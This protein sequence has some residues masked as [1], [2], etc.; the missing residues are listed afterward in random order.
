M[1]SHSS[2]NFYPGSLLKSWLLVFGLF[3]LSFS[4]SGQ[5]GM[6]LYQ[7][8]FIPQASYLN[9]ANTPHARFYISLPGISGI[10]AGLRT[11]YFSMKEGNVGLGT[12][13][14]DYD[15]DA[16]ISTFADRANFTNT[17]GLRLGADLFGFGIRSGQ[18]YIGFN[19][20]EEF[21]AN[22]EFPDEAFWFLDEYNQKKAA[23]DLP[24]LMTGAR[25]SVSQYRPITLQ[26]AYDI[27]PTFTLGGQVSYISGV[28]TLNATSDTLFA[29][30]SESPKGF[31]IVGSLRSQS[32]GFI[33]ADSSNVK[34]VFLNPQNSGV[35]F[36]LGGRLTTL[37]DRLDITFSAVNFGR[38]FWTQKVG[39]TYINDATFEKA[40]SLE[41]VLDALL[42][43]QE[44]ANFSF[45]QNLTPEFY[46]GANYFLNRSL[47]VGAL[48]QA[49]PVF[50][51]LQSAFGLF[52]NARPT[53][54]FGVT[55]GY[56]YSN[57]THNIPLGI[58]FQPGP[59]QIYLISDNALAFAFPG[60]A[61][62]FHLNMGINLVFGKTMRPW[63]ETAPKAGA[64]ES[65]PGVYVPE[66][67]PEEET[68]PEFVADTIPAPGD[69]L[70]MEDEPDVTTYLVTSPMFLY[71]GP[72]AATTVLDTIAPNTVMTVLQ[73]RLPD[74]W[75]VEY[76]DQSGW[77]QPRSIRP[78]LELPVSEQE[79]EEL[80]EPT[81]SFTPQDYIMLD[82]T[83]MRETPAETA[84][85]I[86]WMKKWD[87][88]VV[89]EKTNSSWWKIRHEG[90]QGYV[91]SAMLNPR[92]ENYVRPEE[93]Q[94]EEPAPQTVTPVPSNYGIY[95]I[96]A[97]TSLRAAAT[98]TSNSLKRLRTGNEVLVLEKTN[99][100]WWKVEASGLTGYVK[101]ANLTDQ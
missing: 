12:R 99:A 48:V 35:A 79:T 65:Y 20:R 5:G 59:I 58:N 39:E 44:K 73:K 101:A 47:S 8:P 43:V 51:S 88:V 15:L 76:G 56:L 45:N 14:R 19:I 91:K 37:D 92:P 46:L 90:R 17:L 100:L 55:S 95:R 25:F 33:E 27:L 42:S 75:Y 84:P 36:G 87:E 69:P 81:V 13:W 41:D 94:T 4:L 10:Q 22:L 64:V 2:F 26:Y 96:T 30:A 52:F 78:A 6:T 67:Q 21:Q 9:P 98:H 49:R 54:W 62:Q 40:D 29:Q 68:R 66:E 60:G 86:H 28:F 93:V 63:P 82:Q 72:S 1:S 74:W 85:E 71:R 23:E 18:H 77:V 32:G 80:P 24:Y 31:D 16:L 7:M 89:I 11:D 50:E 70:Y 83:A 53:N 97:S 34:N 3:A 38:I 61:R 57:R